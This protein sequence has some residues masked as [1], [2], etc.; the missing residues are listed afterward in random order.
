MMRLPIPAIL[1]ALV[2]V[3]AGS[4]LLNVYFKSDRPYT[5][6]VTDIPYRQNKTFVLDYIPHRIKF[7][8]NISGAWYDVEMYINGTVNV[9]YGYETRAYWF[10]CHNICFFSV[11]ND[12]VIYIEPVDVRSSKVKILVARIWP[13]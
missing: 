8:S 12:T 9:R 3:A 5:L 13:P 6:N 1:A 2:V 7:V 10:V 11:M 4:V